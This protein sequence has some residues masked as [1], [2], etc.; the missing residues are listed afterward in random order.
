MLEVKK[1]NKTQYST[2]YKCGESIFKSHKTGRG[3]YH[4]DTRENYHKALPS[5]IV[6]SK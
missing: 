2:C 5:E 4:V 1:D 3:W 6:E